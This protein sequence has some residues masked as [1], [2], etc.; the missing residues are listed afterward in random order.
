MLISA[1]WASVKSI[2]EVPVIAVGERSVA[3]CGSGVRK[4]EG[5]ETAIT[6]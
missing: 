2:G 4:L 5:Y 3:V 6:V 1:V